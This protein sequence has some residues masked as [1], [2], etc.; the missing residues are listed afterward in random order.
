M[1]HERGK[2]AAIGID[3]RSGE[4][5][6]GRRILAVLVL[7]SGEPVEVGLD[8]GRRIAGLAVLPASEP[9]EREAQIVTL[10]RLDLGVH[11]GEI[12]LARLR[13]H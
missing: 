3:V 11:Q 8:P 13:F 2:G 9:Q 7:G 4:C 5:R 12:E 1:P 10:R 6:E